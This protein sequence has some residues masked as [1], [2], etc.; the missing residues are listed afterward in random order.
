MDI[1]HVIRGEDHISNTPADSD[2][3]KLWASRSQFAHCPLSWDGWRAAFPNVLARSRHGL[4]PARDS[5]GGPGELFDAFGLVRW[6]QENHRVQERHREILDQQDQQ[7]CGRSFDMD[8]LK[9]D[10]PPSNI[11]QAD[12]AVLTDLLVPLLKEEG[13][14]GRP[15]TEVASELVS[16]FKAACHLERF[17]ERAAFLFVKD[18][19]I[20]RYS[21]LGSWRRICRDGFRRLLPL[22]AWERSTRSTKG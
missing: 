22:T 2:F 11:K 7:D 18:F 21:G 13:F 19:Q 3:M 9:L 5:S 20:S 10:Q 15:S 16:L 1:S 12:T 8:K 6:E 17:L 4:P 14:I